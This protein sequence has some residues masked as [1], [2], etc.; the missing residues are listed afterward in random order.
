[1]AAFLD[2]E[3][4]SKTYGRGGGVVAA[5]DDLSLQVAE[6]GIFGLL[7]PNGA[8]KSTLLRVVLGLVHPDKGSFRLFGKSLREAPGVL[9]SVGG[10]IETTRLYPFLTGEE[11]LSVLAGY[12]GVSCPGP[13]RRALL[14]RV[15]LEE[16]AGRRVGGYSLGMKQRLGIASTL[17]GHPRAVVLDEPTNGMDP[18]GIV[19]M[20]DLFRDLA[21]RDGVTVMLSSHMLDEVQRVCDHVAILHRGRLA[22]SGA[23]AELIGGDHLLLDIRPVE[24]ACRLIGDAARPQPDGRI[25][26]S[27]TRDEAPRL[28]SRLTAAGLELYEAKWQ[29]RDLERYFVGLVEEGGDDR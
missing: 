13:E 22:A 26:V 14:A 10:L 21:E 16:A 3:K 28:L 20:R 29:G 23:V 17:I 1:M 2:V 12:A 7:G 25:K 9:R 15:G 24:E 11:T 4:V 19:E 6:G 18:V 5:L 8:G 27:I